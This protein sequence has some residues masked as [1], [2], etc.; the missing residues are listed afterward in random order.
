LL[1]GI[2]FATRPGR[3]AEVEALCGGEAFLHHAAEAMGAIFDAL[4]VKGNNFTLLY[5]FPGVTAGETS[6]DQRDLMGEGD[7]LDASLARERVLALFLDDRVRAA[8]RKLA[9]LIGDP[10]DPE[11][12]TSF[13]AWVQRHKVRVLAEE[14]RNHAAKASSARGALGVVPR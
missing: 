3:E 2:T 11:D 5:D 13:A 14:H 10:F 12:A 8:L 1:F 6:R 9:P 7:L 4:F